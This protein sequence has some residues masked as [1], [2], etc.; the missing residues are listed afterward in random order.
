MA[1]HAHTPASR[2]ADIAG[3]QCDIHQRSVGA[4]I[5]VA[6]DQALFVGEHRP[7]PR[8][9]LLGFGDPTR[10][11]ADVIGVKPRDIS[12]FAMPTLFA[13]TISSKPVVDVAD[14]IRSIQPFAAISVISA[15]KRIRSVPELIAR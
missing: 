5:V 9:A 7:P 11:F 6:P 3:R 12:G 15:L 14:E 4:V 8:A 2:A 10:R 1:A 13:A